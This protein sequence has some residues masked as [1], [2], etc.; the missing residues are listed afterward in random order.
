MQKSFLESWLDVIRTARFK[1]RAGV[2]ERS[3]LMQSSLAR[4][5]AINI[6]ARAVSI[7]V[8]K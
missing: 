3:E 6:K 7:D 1:A 2:T 5:K 4:R 8:T